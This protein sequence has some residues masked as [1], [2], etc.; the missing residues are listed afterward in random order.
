MVINAG[1]CHYAA[2]DGRSGGTTSAMSKKKEKSLDTKKF[3]AL[4]S[5]QSSSS[6][7]LGWHAFPGVGSDSSSS[8]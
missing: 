3:E 1:R 4:C 5:F 6:N 8:I 7:G 2:V